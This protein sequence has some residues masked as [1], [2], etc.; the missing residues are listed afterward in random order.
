MVLSC[1]GNAISRWPRTFNIVTG[2]GLFGLSD[3][4][5]QSIEKRNNT[6][7][8]KMA[9]VPGDRRLASMFVMGGMTGIFFPW[10]YKMLD[11]YFVRF[12]PK[13][14][15]QQLVMSPIWNSTFLAYCETVRNPFDDLGTRIYSRWEGDLFYILQR[16]MPFWLCMNGA[17]FYF[18][19]LHLRGPVMYF[20]N[21]CWT[22]YLSMI[23]HSGVKSQLS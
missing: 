21:C 5:A 18:T 7:S 1:L 4:V 20:V 6:K 11:K 17:N 2:S 14:I 16:S 23:G 15:S 22:I 9:D 19:P 12:A 3:G 13:M 10:W 8:T